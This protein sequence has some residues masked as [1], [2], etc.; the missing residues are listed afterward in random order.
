MAQD[1][2]ISYSALEHYIL[3]TLR[4]RFRQGA[5]IAE[6]AQATTL[7]PGTLVAGCLWRRRVSRGVLS[8]SQAALTLL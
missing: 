2:T 6:L 8:S 4:T 5:T 7:P 1:M 3:D